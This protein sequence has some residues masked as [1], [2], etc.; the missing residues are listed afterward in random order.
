VTDT[1]T[2]YTAGTGID[3][4]NTTHVISATGGGC[5]INVSTT[6]TLTTASLASI[7]TSGCHSNS[8]TIYGVGY[9][10][11]ASTNMFPVVLRVLT[12]GAVQGMAPA[13]S[14]GYGGSITGAV[15]GTIHVL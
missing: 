5:T 11:D 9:V 10:T 7:M 13:L 12:T 14:D 8:E 2:T 3:I 6:T 15:R 4:N 1:D